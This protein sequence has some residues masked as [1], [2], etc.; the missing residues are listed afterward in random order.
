[1]ENVSDLSAEALPFPT[2]PERRC[3]TSFHVAG[4]DVTSGFFLSDITV[5]IT[6]AAQLHVQA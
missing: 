3:N 6:E 1:M 4:S 2:A 5:V